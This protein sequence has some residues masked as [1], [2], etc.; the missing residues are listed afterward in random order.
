MHSKLDFQKAVLRLEFMTACTYV[1][2][3]SK[4]VGCV[5]TVDT[6]LVQLLN[7]KYRT[8]N[9]VALLNSTCIVPLHKYEVT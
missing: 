9:N 4:M 6:S 2:T 7:R 3:H 1:N 5:V 8:A